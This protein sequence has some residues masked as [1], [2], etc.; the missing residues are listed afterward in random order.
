MR[1]VLIFINPYYRAGR[2]AFLVALSDRHRDRYGRAG[3]LGFD[4]SL[5]LWIYWCSVIR[6]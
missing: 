3:D 2:S 6:V 4:S 1:L 5:L